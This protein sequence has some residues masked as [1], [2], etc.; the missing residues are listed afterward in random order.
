MRTSTWSPGLW[1]PD[2]QLF[3]PYWGSLAWHSSL[4][5]R[6]WRISRWEPKMSGKSWLGMVEP[7]PTFQ[8]P[9][10]PN[11]F[12]KNRDKQE[13]CSWDKRRVSSASPH[14]VTSLALFLDV[15]EVTRP[16]G[17]S[18]ITCMQLGYP[19][20]F[21]GQKS[22]TTPPNRLSNN[23]RSTVGKKLHRNR[24]ITHSLLSMKL[25]KSKRAVVFPSHCP[26]CVSFFGF[27][28]SPTC[29][30]IVAP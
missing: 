20:G 14:Q 4:M 11:F 22:W 16:D 26:P 1:Q 13:A 30:K 9:P 23:C 10:L 7:A 27:T 8:P 2:R 17:K 24:H 25:R 18:L 6:N 19:T 29:S 12:E 3:R 21:F 15:T 28:Q 5:I